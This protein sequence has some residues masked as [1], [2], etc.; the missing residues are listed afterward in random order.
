MPTPD[1]WLYAPDQAVPGPIADR[2]LSGLDDLLADESQPLPDRLARMAGLV[3]RLSDTYLSAQDDEAWATGALTSPPF[4][5]P[6]TPYWMY[7]RAVEPLGLM[8]CLML[9]TTA[10]HVFE[11]G[12]LE[13][14][15]EERFFLPKDLELMTTRFDF[16]PVSLGSYLRHAFSRR[17]FVE[18]EG[19]AFQVHFALLAFT[20][21]RYVAVCRAI[22]DGREDST[23]PADVEGAATAFELVTSGLNLFDQGIRLDPDL[24][25]R[26]R[27][28]DTLAR[29]VGVL[30]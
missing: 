13:R 4:A 14:T 26:F 1:T 9:S 18:A 8:I 2:I 12:P 5:R 10:A 3:N 21:I 7:P 19:I 11:F 24:G 23:G 6:I 30:L 28:P 15:P 25:A 27:H 29:L 22:A 16:D 17:A 20:T